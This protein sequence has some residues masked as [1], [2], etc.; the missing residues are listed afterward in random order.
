[1]RPSRLA[2]LIDGENISGNIADT[3]FAKIADH[4]SAKL[5]RIYGD[6]SNPCLK[7]WVGPIARHAIIAQQVFKNGK[8][9]TD[10]T[11][12]MDAME[13]LLSERFDGFA[14]FQQTRTSRA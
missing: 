1:M 12:I 13:L 5:R 8:N 11:L 2:V 6:F 7:T 3:L 4:G 9:A 14:S 10:M